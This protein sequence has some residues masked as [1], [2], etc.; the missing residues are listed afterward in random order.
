MYKLYICPQTE[1]L[2]EHYAKSIEENS[3]NH[4]TDSGFDLFVPEEQLYIVGEYT[5]IDHLVKCKMVLIDNNGNE[6]PT[7]YLMHPRSSTAK[8][9]N[10]ILANSTGVIDMD[11]RGNIKASVF[12]NITKHHMLNLLASIKDGANAMFNSCKLDQYTRIVQLCA[13]NYMPFKVEL[14]NSLDETERGAGG[15]GSTGN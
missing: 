12:C 10:L 6:K 5:M 1:K 4:S 13:P 9:Y 11:Y 15:F 2:K 8:K 3:S 14:V 7:G